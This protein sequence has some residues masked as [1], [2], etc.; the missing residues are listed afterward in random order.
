MPWKGVLWN[1]RGCCPTA[2]P[3][4]SKLYSGTVISC[5]QPPELIPSPYERNWKESH[6]RLTLTRKLIVVNSLKKRKK[7]FQQTRA[8]KWTHWKGNASLGL[9]SLVSPSQ[10]FL[11][12]KM[13]VN[14]V[15][16]LIIF[17]GSLTW[18]PYP[19]MP[20]TCLKIQK[21]TF[22]LDS[23]SQ[24]FQIFKLSVKSLH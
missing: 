2:R 1:S 9:S 18:T 17:S 11:H 7:N 21:R 5:L 8:F 20:I 15:K 3:G 12:Q 14:K 22:P 6:Q 19:G 23:Q 16:M 4:K 10:D 24:W 13:C